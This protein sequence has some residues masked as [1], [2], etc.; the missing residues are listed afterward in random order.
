MNF[1]NSNKIPPPPIK[2]LLLGDKGVGKSAFLV[3]LVTNRFITEYSSESGKKLKLNSGLLP[4]RLEIVK[5]I[6][7]KQCTIFDYN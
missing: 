5:F 4:V 6:K 1:M 3:K 7:R 2:L